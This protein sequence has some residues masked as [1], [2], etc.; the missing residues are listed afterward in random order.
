MNPTIRLGIAAVLLLLPVAPP[1]SAS[2]AKGHTVKGLVLNSDGKT[3]G[4]HI[5]PVVFLQGAATPFTTRTEAGPDGRFKFKNVQPGTYTIVAAVPR[6]GEVRRTVEVGP[7]T[8]DSKGTVSVTLSFERKSSSDTNYSVSAAELAIPDSAWQLYSKA[9]DHISKRDFERA[10]VLLKKA[11]E[12]APQF[13]AAL[14]QLGT[15][16]FHERLY[17]DA[18]AYFRE[19]LK[20]N[21]NAYPPLLNLGGTLLVQ[22]RTAEALELN[23]KAVDAKPGDALAQIQL[24][25]SYFLVGDLGAAEEHLRMGKALDPAHYSLPQLTLVEIYARRHDD[26]AIARELEEFLKLHPDSTAS[27]VLRRSLEQI[28]NR[29]SN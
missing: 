9:Q 15:I 19:A 25:R 18:E 27:P 26:A 2:E 22:G 23:R 10:R 8:G 13:A 29:M 16:A 3:F 6:A 4:R 21:P 20:Q 12:S 7:G 14:N 28:R 1:G 24:G 17:A 11:V 5:V